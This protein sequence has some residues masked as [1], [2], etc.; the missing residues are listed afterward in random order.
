LDE[1]VI[2]IDNQFY[3]RATSSRL[4]GRTRVLKRGETFAICDRLGDIASVGLP[5]LGLYHEGTRFLSRLA[6][7]LEGQRPLLLSSGLR[8]DSGSFVA[9]LTN[10]DVYRDGHMAV[11]RGTV[12][13][14]R[15]VWTFPGGFSQAISLRNYGL[16][17]TSVRMSVAVDAD[18]AD[19]FEVRGTSREK[20]G[21]RLPA[22]PEE[23]GVR[24]SYAGR[25]G[26]VRETH[27]YC[28]PQ[29]GEVRPGGVVF[30]LRLEPGE[31]RRLLQTIYCQSSG[32]D[33]PTPRLPSA[34]RAESAAAEK[35]TVACPHEA[36]GAWLRR[37]A[38]DLEMMTTALPSGPYPFAGVPWFC[39]PFGRDGIVTALETLWLDPSLAKGV[40][41]YLSETQARELD[42]EHDAEPGKILHEARKGEMAALGEIPFG[43]YYGS[44]DAT[45]LFVMLAAAYHERT[46]DDAFLETLWPHVEAALDWIDSWGD[47]DGDG[48][49]E[50][51]RQS[52]RGLVQQG[53]RD[54]QDAVFHADGRLADGPIALAEV[55][56][57]V[58]AARLGAARLTEALGHRGRAETLRSAGDRMR[59]AFDEAYWCEE[60]SSYAMA[61]DGEKRPCRVACSSAAHALWTGIALPERAESVARTLFS[62]DGFS[63]WGIRTIARGQARFNPMSYHNGSIWPHDNALAAAGLAA[64]GRQDLAMRLLVAMLDVSRQME[65]RRLPELFCGFERHEGEPPTLYPLACAPQSWSAGAVFLL[66]QCCLGLSIDA[67]GRRFRFESPKLPP[68]LRD[69]RLQNLRGATGTLDVHVETR[70]EEVGVSTSRP[71]EGVEVVVSTDAERFRHD[72]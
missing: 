49:V 7:T 39:T 35:A 56:G 1:D 21:R 67:G 66:L 16:E 40:L 47:R 70:G 60:L 61:L 13:L 71:A 57:Y 29:P 3:I 58:Y 68:F 55:Q 8:D 27:L 41:S 59:R 33:R 22:I 72:S 31:K 14:V 24:M 44:V 53:W 15:E 69:I 23:R 18:F 20:K 51:H 46:G 42:P 32:E 65:L 34:A 2:E 52:P 63:G 28:D 11:P 10:A 37:S 54:S 50:Y 12:H 36:F 26:V 9:H 38:A 30:S 25:D 64:Y 62:D 45:P 5:E 19:V 4:D 48:F 6:L 43:R 17:P